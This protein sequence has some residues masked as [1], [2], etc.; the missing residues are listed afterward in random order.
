MSNIYYANEEFACPAEVI[1]QQLCGWIASGLH[2]KVKGNLIKSWWGNGQIRVTH[3]SLKTV[4]EFM[5][6]LDVSALEDA[7]K[8]DC[9]CGRCSL[10]RYTLAW[11]DG[12]P[13][14]IVC[15]SDHERE[16]EVLK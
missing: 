15:A 10:S 16:M 12:E 9:A 1:Y 7:C 3:S 6:L 11:I 13:V 5:R 8:E 4:A 2:F 14:C